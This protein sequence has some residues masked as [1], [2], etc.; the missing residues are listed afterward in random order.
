MIS[1]YNG[2]STNK[3]AA[4]IGENLEFTFYSMNNSW[5]IYWQSANH[6][7]P[8]YAYFLTRMP[9]NGTSYLCK[10][11]NDYDSSSTIFKNIVSAV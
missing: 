11:S 1:I 5:W 3:T 6:Y 2:N 9:K 10:T 4:N 7:K 8:D